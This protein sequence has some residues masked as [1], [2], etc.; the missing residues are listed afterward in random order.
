VDLQIV[1]DLDQMDTDDVFEDTLASLSPKVPAVEVADITEALDTPYELHDLTWETPKKTA[2]KIRTPSDSSESARIDELSGDEEE[3]VSVPMP[4]QRHDTL[5]ENIG[6]RS[7]TPK[8]KNRKRG[9]KGGKKAQK[10]APAPLV[11][12]GGVNLNTISLAAIA[13]G[14]AAVGVGC[15]GIV[16]S[17]RWN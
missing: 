10:K 8:K 7:S 15:V 6:S 17:T 5:S 12:E 2:D 11:G 13:A 9:K 1:L 14:V 16:I 3:D 4:G